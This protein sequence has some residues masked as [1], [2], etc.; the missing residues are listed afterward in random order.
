MMKNSIFAL[1]LAALAASGCASKPKTLPMRRMFGVP[2]GMVQ[3]QPI[4]AEG[5]YLELLSRPTLYAGKPGTLVFA[6]RNSG[7]KSVNIDEWFRDEAYNVKLLIQPYLPG[8]TAPDP[9]AWIELTEPEQPN[10]VHYP[11][12]LMPDNKVMIAKQLDFIRHMRISP[13]RERRF[14]LRGQLTLK[15][16]NLGTEVIVLHVLP[17]KDKETA[18]P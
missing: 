5:L 10:P 11:L 8:M 13:G 17:P 1:L 14:F 15:S 3:Y 4:P 7:V 16:L 2:D 18:K 6:L 12:A 9:E